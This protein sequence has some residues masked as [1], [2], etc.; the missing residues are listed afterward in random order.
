MIY[1]IKIT[2]DTMPEATIEVEAVDFNN[3]VK[4][5]HR[6]FRKAHNI[7]RMPVGAWTTFAGKRVA[8]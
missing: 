2:I 4:A 7:K 6:E 1:T 8:K 5:A 3:A